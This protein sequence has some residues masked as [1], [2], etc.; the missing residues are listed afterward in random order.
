MKKLKSHST[1]S[2]FD[3]QFITSTISTMLVLLLLGL[4]V[5]FTLGASNLSIFV[6]ENFTFSVLINDDMK[7]ADIMILQK[8]LERE[9]FVKES[10]YISKQQALKEQ[11]EAMGTNP[12]EFLGYNP[13]KA[14]I[15]IKLNSNYANP[16]SISI[17][18]KAIKQESNVGEILYQKELINAVNDNIRNISI[19]LLILA[20]ILTLISFALINNTIKLAIY[21]KRFLI[22][23]MKLVGASWSFIRR[24]FLLRNFWIGVIAAL[25]ANTILIGCAYWLVFYFPDLIRVVT[26]EIM[27]IVIIAVMTFG[28]IITY[29]CAYF[30]VNKY[31]RMKHD[32][33]YAV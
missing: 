29:T 1:P 5:F 17:V 24:P 8:K 9:P 3:M 6:R 4:V 19:I 30:S 23:T 33:L 32:S 12:Q 2:Y 18:E 11:A 16:D 20:G 25:L 10:T 21:A 26:P 7:E 27:L 15:E 28:I 31:L 14:S 13:F 22:H